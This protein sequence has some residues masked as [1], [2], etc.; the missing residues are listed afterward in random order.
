[1]GEHLK[2]QPLA[3]LLVS[4]LLSCIIG[5]LQCHLCLSLVNS[6]VLLWQL[7]G[8]TTQTHQPTSLYSQQQTFSWSAVELSREKNKGFPPIWARRIAE[9]GILCSHMCPTHC[10]GDKKLQ[11]VAQ[12][13]RT[14]CTILQ[15]G[16]HSSGLSWSSGLIVPPFVTF[17]LHCYNTSTKLNQKCITVFPSLSL[18]LYVNQLPSALCYYGTKGHFPNWMIKLYPILYPPSLNLTGPTLCQ[19][20]DKAVQMWSPNPARRTPW[21]YYCNASPHVLNEPLLYHSNISLSQNTGR[22]ICGKTDLNHSNWCCWL[23]ELLTTKPCEFLPVVPIK[24]SHSKT[25][26]LLQDPRTRKIRT[27]GIKSMI[28]SKVSFIDY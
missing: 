24:S 7:E 27:C 22:N 15:G 9:L 18:H 26:K 6:V 23:V 12:C 16:R 14:G 28:F 25:P 10:G 13:G 8:S 21:L 17:S 1:M 11:G 5:S 2:W 4:V 19:N 3:L 20:Q